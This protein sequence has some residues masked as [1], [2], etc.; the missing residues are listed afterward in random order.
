VDSAGVSA[1][2]AATAEPLRF[3]S[4]A[5]VAGLLAAV[6]GLLALAISNI[7]ATG[8]AGFKTAITLHTGIGPYSGKELISWTAWIASWFVLHFALRKKEL[9][10]QR[11]FGIFMVGLLVAVLLVWPPVFEAIAHAL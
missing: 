5:I 4:G 9:D 11:W 8:D 3:P 10:L 1:S 6:I 7:A 2:S